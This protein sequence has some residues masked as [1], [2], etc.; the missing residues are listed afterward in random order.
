MSWETRERGGRYYTRSMRENGR[1]FMFAAHDLD[2]AIPND[3]P[4]RQIAGRT[5]PKCLLFPIFEPGFRYQSAILTV[6]RPYLRDV[7]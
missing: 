2:W 5:G 7:G 3:L 6:P 1:I 4:Q